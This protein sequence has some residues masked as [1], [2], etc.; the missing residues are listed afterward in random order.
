MIDFITMFIF[1]SGAFGISRGVETME[2]V[3]PNTC[4]IG[5]KNNLTPNDITLIKV[6]NN[7]EY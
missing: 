7:R 4:E 2:A 6:R 5:G 3:D 1:R